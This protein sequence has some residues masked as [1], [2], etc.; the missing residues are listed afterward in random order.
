MPAF[1]VI[2][3]SVLSL[4]ILA[5]SDGYEGR[6]HSLWYCDAQEA[7]RYQWFETAFM[8]PVL[9]RARTRQDPFALNPGDDSAG[10]VAS[11]WPDRAQVAWPFTPVSTSELA[12]LIGRWAGW[13]ADAAQGTLRRPNPMPERS[14]QG[15]WRQS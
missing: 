1:E 4:Q 15:N 13:F 3:F 5:G 9:V 10:A 14:P 7:R 6:S 11:G 12:E 2:A 8:I